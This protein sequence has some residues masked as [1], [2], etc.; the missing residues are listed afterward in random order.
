MKWNEI[1]ISLPD[2][3]AE[4]VADLLYSKNIKG[5]AIEGDLDY[6]SLQN[7]ETFWDYIDEELLNSEGEGTSYI[8][9]YISEEEN[10]DINELIVELITEI[11]EFE[12]FGFDVS[13][14][15]VKS[16]LVDQKDWEDSWKAYYKPIK[17]TDRIVV[18]PEWEEYES[19][20]EE[21]VLKIDP[22]MAFGTG[23][24]ETT[25]MCMKAIERYMPKDIYFLDIGC[26][27]GILAMTAAL[28]GAKKSV[29]IDFDPVAVRVAKENIELN[30]LTAKVEILQGNLCDKV[31]GKYKMIAANIMADVIIILCEDVNTFLDE[32]GYFI[33]SGII[34][35]KLDMVINKIE[36]IGLDIIDV[37]KDGEWAAVVSKRK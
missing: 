17:I 1:I 29:G 31:S 2:N 22:G 28:L 13:K 21:V 27:S 6:K 36:E 16:N 20:G 7:D 3:M 18:Q 23:S 8:K 12:V 34:H 14:V 4:L 10:I 26:G 5:V 37:I 35:E 32:E 33:A 15:S 30:K 25:S 24:H 11:N 9:A 19:Q